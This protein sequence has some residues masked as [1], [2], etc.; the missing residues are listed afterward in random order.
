MKTWEAQMAQKVRR[1][2]LGKQLRR[3]AATMALALV[4]MVGIMKGSASLSVAS[5][6]TDLSSFIESQVQGVL[7]PEMTEDPASLVWEF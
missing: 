2:Y 3:G 7:S 5:S 1:R 6:T 4:M